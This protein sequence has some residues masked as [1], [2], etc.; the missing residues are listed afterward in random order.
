MI[1]R[2]LKKSM[3]RTND[4]NHTSVRVYN[5][6]FNSPDYK[7]DISFPNVI[8]ISS[9]GDKESVYNLRN[10]LRRNLFIHDDYKPEIATY[11]TQ[12]LYK[13][14]YELNDDEK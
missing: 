1:D 2:D 8:R 11:M 4:L 9:H 3:V 5:E 10:D 6:R 14:V 12:R 13:G 7:H